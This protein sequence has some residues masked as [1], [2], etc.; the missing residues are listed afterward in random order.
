MKRVHC[1]LLGLLPPLLT[2]GKPQTWL[3]LLQPQLLLVIGPI[4]SLSQSR[5]KTTSFSCYE[6]RVLKPCVHRG[7]AE[8][9]WRHWEDQTLGEH[10]SP[11]WKQYSTRPVTLDAV[12]FNQHSR[13][14][15][16]GG[17]RFHAA[18]LISL[19]PFPTTPRA[20]FK[21]KQ[22]HSLF[23]KCTKQF[24]KHPPCVRGEGQEVKG[25]SPCPGAGVAQR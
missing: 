19:P 16:T 14:S 20:V 4:I 9:L 25:Q 5:A 24:V 12:F 11:C 17:E 3:D 7:P 22:I 13:L 15:S 1:P 2:P 23:T 6:T 10:T 18:V 21:P 8:R